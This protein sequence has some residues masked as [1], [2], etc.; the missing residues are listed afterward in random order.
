MCTSPD[1]DTFPREKVSM[2]LNYKFSDL[3]NLLLLQPDGLP[4]R[5][6]MKLCDVAEHIGTEEMV[7]WI[8]ST[9]NAVDG[10]FYIRPGQEFDV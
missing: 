2:S 9:P 8:R 3:C 4:E 5:I 6:Y 7:H 1:A 10:Q